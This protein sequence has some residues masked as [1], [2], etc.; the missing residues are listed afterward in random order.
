MILT[1]SSIA[2]SNCLTTLSRVINSKNPLPILDCFLFEVKGNELKITASDG[3]NTL[4]SKV[5]LEEAD[6]EGIFAVS[7][8]TI[9]NAVKELPEQPLNLDVNLEE[10]TIKVIYQNGMY[11]FTIQNGNEYPRTEEIAENAHTIMLDGNELNVNITRSLFATAQDEI[12]PVMN[13]VYFDLKEDGLSIVAS[14]GH[15]LVKNVLFSVKDENPSSF[16][17]PKKPA[18]LLKSILTKDCGDVTIQYND[19]NAVFS[20]N[21]GTLICRL[22]EGKYPNYNSVI[23]KENPNCITIDRKLLLSA[24]KRVLPFASESSQLVR[25]HIDENE[26]ILSSEDID[27]ATSA[28]ERLACDY[29]GQ[30]MDIG[31]KGSSLQEILGNIECNEVT[32]HLGD[33]S[34]AGI[35]EP[36][37]QPDKEEILMLIM[38]MLLND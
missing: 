15:K 9:L 24:L 11:D 3:E 18:S 28:K 37:E 13:G 25:L 12:R 38:P 19:K 31:F 21:N 26:L 30:K 10:N 1:L 14:D 32:I 16:I 4:I 35:I 27:F 17:L 22:I 2:L 5:V 7:N 29:E 36:V 20:F 33:P 23:P 8:S 6:S 34:R